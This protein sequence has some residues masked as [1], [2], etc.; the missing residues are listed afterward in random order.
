MEFQLPSEFQ[1]LCSIFCF[2]ISHFGGSRGLS[3]FESVFIFLMTMLFSLSHLGNIFWGGPDHVFFFPPPWYS[4]SFYLFFKITLYKLC[5]ILDVCIQIYPPMVWQGSLVLISLG[6]VLQTMQCTD[7]E[8]AVPATL[9]GACAP[10]A[11]IP[12]EMWNISF[13]LK[14]VSQTCPVIPSTLSNEEI[15][16]LISITT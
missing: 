16:L 8:H 6:S 11:H 12:I 13:R 14:V 1:S 10:V 4:G 15:T 2:H 9:M 7:T 5:Y 3:C